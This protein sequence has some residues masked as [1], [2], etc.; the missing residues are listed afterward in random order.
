MLVPLRWVGSSV[1]QLT[2][3]FR[4]V[5]CYDW[6]IKMLITDNI[7]SYSEVIIIIIDWSSINQSA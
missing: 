1:E 4:V 3:K 6:R 2:H 5:T 7:A